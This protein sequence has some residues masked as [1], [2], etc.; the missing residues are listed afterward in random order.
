MPFPKPSHPVPTQ[1][2]TIVIYIKDPTGVPADRTAH[3]EL[4]LTDSEG[5]VIDTVQGNLVPHLTPA[6]LSGLQTLMNDLRV[7]ALE[8]LP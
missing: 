7:K 1:V 8:A 2:G 4:R 6:Q 3:F 5:N